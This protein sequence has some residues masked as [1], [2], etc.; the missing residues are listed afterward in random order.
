MNSV[1]CSLWLYTWFSKCLYLFMSSLWLFLHH[2]ITAILSFSWS[3]FE[4]VSIVLHSFC[5]SCF[6]CLLKTLLHVMH[7]LYEFWAC[8]SVTVALIKHCNV[9]SVL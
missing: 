6:K 2:N 1:S 3:L 9:C 7:S 4:F 8:E 5:V